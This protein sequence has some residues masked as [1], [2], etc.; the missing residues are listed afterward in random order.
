MGIDIYALIMDWKPAVEAYRAAGG[1]DFYWDAS[2]QIDFEVE[3][4][5]RRRTPLPWPEVPQVV[6]FAEEQWAP[7]GK[8]FTAAG[9]F[10]LELS[11]HLEPELLARTAPVFDT[12]YPQKMSDINDLKADSGGPDDFDVLYALRPS[13]VELMLE[14]IEALPWEAMR[15]AGEGI[16]LSYMGQAAGHGLDFSQFKGIIDIH[17]GW[18]R[19]AAATDRGLLVFWSV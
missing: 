9:T 13:S 16:E 7:P 3:R 11:D 8:A 19:E 4:A 15:A 1:L 6:P 14:R 18:L 5:R 17:V 10:Y 2:A 12:I